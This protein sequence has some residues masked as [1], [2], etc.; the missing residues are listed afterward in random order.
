V[1]TFPKVEAHRP[2]STP[3]PESLGVETSE[4][5]A[6]FLLPPPSSAT[7]EGAIR[8]ELGLAGTEEGEEAGG[9]LPKALEEQAGSLPPLVAWYARR[10]LPEGPLTEALS[11]GEGGWKELERAAPDSDLPAMRSYLDA[12]PLGRAENLGAVAYLHWLFRRASG[13]APRPATAEQL[14][15]FREAEGN[16]GV[17]GA[18]F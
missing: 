17:R 5:S 2:S 10:L 3:H 1:I 9:A 11:P 18:D 4:L 16:R 7:P 8:Q 12:L 6:L 15:L 14:P 13:E